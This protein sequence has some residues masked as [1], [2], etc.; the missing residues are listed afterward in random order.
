[1][2]QVQRAEDNRTPL[3]S[4]HKELDARMV[5]FAGYEMPVQYP[6]GIRAE[7]EH[8]R[9]KAS[10]FDISHMG[11]ISITGENIDISLEKLVPGD[12]Q[13]LPPFRQRYTVFTNE[14]GGIIDDLM[15]TRL[16]D[17]FFLVVNAAGKLDDYKY[18]QSTLGNKNNISMLEDKALLAIQGPLAVSI[19][20]AYL[21]AIDDLPFLAVGQFRLSGID[22]LI[23]RCGYT[24][25]DGFEISV[26]AEKAEELARILLTDK[27][28][29]P[30]GLGARD[31]LRLEAGLCLYG[32]D[33]NES[34][35][36]VEA[37]LIWIIAKKYRSDNPVR[38]NFP[39][40]KNIL[41]Q[42]SEGPSR[43]R[44]G[45]KPE[46]KILVREGSMIFDSDGEKV[47]IIS[48]GG[49]GQTIGGPI[50][51]GYVN[52]TSKDNDGYK[53]N[54]RNKTYTL[55]QVRLPFVKHRYHIK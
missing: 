32:H 54:I 35:S 41:Q 29:M 11:Q 13:S 36:P 7:H 42:I 8:T 45:F 18:L 34:I 55:D 16:P 30:A 26:S 51:M 9:N 5:A 43:I 33:L 25:E 50:A 22:C 14:S 15:I 21:A 38:A 17:S 1:M 53:V 40:A 19:L 47:G 31:S 6:T 28:L 20:S 48:S 27:R 10:I 3:Y 46:G 23:H 37:D 52:T 49:Y 24:G 4:L 2:N 12:I 44:R 39:G